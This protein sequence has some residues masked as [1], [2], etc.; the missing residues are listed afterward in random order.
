MSSCAIP[1]KTASCER[2][3][4]ALAGLQAAGDEVKVIDLYAEGFDPVMSRTE[5]LDHLGSP[6]NRPSL[7][8][9]FDALQWCER[10]VLVYPTWFGGQP[11]M[12]KGWFDRVWMNDVAFTLPRGRV[13]F[14]ASCADSGGSRL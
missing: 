14:E 8:H 13:G 10:L 5:K 9:H 6:A 11:A 2:P 4:S 3:S 12:L 7:A 1:G